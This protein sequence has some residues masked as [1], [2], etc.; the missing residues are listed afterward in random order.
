MIQRCTKDPILYGP[1]HAIFHVSLQSFGK[2]STH[3]PQQSG[4]HDGSKHWNGII[5][6]WI[7]SKGFETHMYEFRNG[8]RSEKLCKRCG[9]DGDGKCAT[10]CVAKVEGCV[11]DQNKG[12]DARSHVQIV[13]KHGRWFGHEEESEPSTGVAGNDAEC[14]GVEPMEFA[15]LRFLQGP[16]RHATLD[17][18]PERLQFSRKWKV[19]RQ[20]V[21][22]VLT[23]ERS[24]DGT[25]C[26]RCGRINRSLAT[27]HRLVELGG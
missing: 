13:G 27:L 8:H 17:G 12:Q 24:V 22:Q 16:N 6:G 3:I 5:G 14:K 10:E 7:G 11:I 20:K 19:S 26:R 1:R 2:E 25:A 15:L 23:P 21:D 18:H 9:D 4:V